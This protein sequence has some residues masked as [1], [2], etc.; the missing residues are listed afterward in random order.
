MTFEYRNWMGIY[1]F[2]ASF[3]VVSINMIFVIH[4]I[5]IQK[6]KS[7]QWRFGSSSDRSCFLNCLKRFFS[8]LD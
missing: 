6:N 4:V 5:L 7:D 2:F 8:A 3:C 1:L